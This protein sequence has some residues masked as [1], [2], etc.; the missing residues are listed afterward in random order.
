M[1]GEKNQNTVILY[2]QT[3]QKGVL[4]LAASVNV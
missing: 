3:R 1:Q 4:K 2:F